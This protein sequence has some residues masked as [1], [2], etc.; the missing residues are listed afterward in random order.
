MEL[1]SCIINCAVG[2]WYLKGQNRLEKSLINH[3]SL[4]ELLKWTKF[5]NKN[6]DERNNYNLKASAF[7]EAI[8]KGYKKI[9]WLDS[10]IYAI[11]NPQPIFDIIENEG[12]FSITNGYNAAQECSDK[13]L[14]YFNISRDDA[15]NIPMCSSGIIGVNLQNEKAN[16]FINNWI[17]SAKNNVFDGS[18]FHDNQSQ[19][20]RFLHHRQDQSSAS[21]LINTLK[22]KL[23]PIN[24]MV[25]Y[26]KEKNDKIIF[27]IQGMV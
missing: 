25:T 6:Y 20:S 11:N 5:P 2:S 23:Y 14:D 21:I 7:E 22:L 12:F 9:L 27:I 19:D 16:I 3:N 18:R 10:S 26:N 8:N 13:C 24:E 4:W 17:I 1:N 15:E